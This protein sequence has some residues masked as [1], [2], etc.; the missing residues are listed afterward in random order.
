MSCCYLLEI[1]L[2]TGFTNRLLLSTED[3]IADRVYK[4]VAS[5]YRG[6]H[7]SAD[8]QISCCYLLETALQ[9]G[10]TNRLLLSTDDSIADWVYK[11]IVA[12]YCSTGVF[13]QEHCAPCSA[14][15]LGLHFN[16]LQYPLTWTHFCFIKN[17]AYFEYETKDVSILQTGLWTTETENL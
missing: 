15:C 7:C 14:R 8:L 1:A 11:W 13:S 17:I 9:A 6:Q 4:W 10:F 3:S 12:F 2:Q 16:N 5:I